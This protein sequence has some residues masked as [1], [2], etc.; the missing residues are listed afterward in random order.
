MLLRN[1]NII[2]LTD[3]GDYGQIPHGAVV[4]TDDVIE[5]V[6]AD[7][8]LPENYS[9]RKENVHDCKGKL[10]TPGLID[11]HTHLVYA[12]NRAEEFERRLQGVSYAEISRQGGGIMATVTATRSVSEDELINESRPRLQALMSEGV[13]TVEIK[14]GYGLDTATEI[15]MLR[16][17][18]RLTREHKL[19]VQRTFL[20]AHAL[21]P[22]YA[23]KSDDYIDL[24]CNEMLPAAV[25]AGVVDAV[26]AFCEKIGF[27]VKQVEKVFETAEQ[28][29]LPI[30]C[31]A[32]QLSN[33]QGAVMSA[34]RGALS[35]DHLEYLSADDVGDIAK[36]G[37][38]A[39]LLP[40]AYYVLK[41]T[42]LPPMAALRN[43]NVPMALATDCNP[44]SSPIFS[45]LLIMN[46]GCTLFG[47][48]P[49]E[50]LAGFTINA[51]KA[52]GYDDQI[53]SIEVG[54]KADLVLWQCDHPAELSYHMG[55]NP[56]SAIMQGGKW[57]QQVQ[58]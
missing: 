8:D 7:Q 22:E 14:S 36:S 55:L 19:R 20:G 9:D 21:P 13:T 23:D 38:V 29:N 42:Q 5:W 54:K 44:G 17:A 47:M 2:C 37:S 28:F 43:H 46:M 58:P 57:R 53:G 4:I 24:V 18:D 30:K 56:C 31:H 40:G 51:A 41:E 50:A 15:K 16:A 11:C 52:L 49:L 39:V 3:S 12:G 10:L 35:V 45:P 1:A 32:E 34:S 6:G 27:S 26:D 33:L 48:T 25:D